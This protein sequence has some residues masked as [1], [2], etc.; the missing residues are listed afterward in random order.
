MSNIIG[1]CFGETSPS[2]I[3]FISK[4]MPAVNEYVYLEYAGKTIMGIIDDLFREVLH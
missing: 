1:R 4:E 3:Y 2:K